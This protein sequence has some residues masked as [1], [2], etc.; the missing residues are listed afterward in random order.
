[1][2]IGTV[3][4]A[5]EQ[6]LGILVKSFF[7]AGILT[8][9]FVVEHGSRKNQNW[10]PNA[11][12]GRL[13]SRADKLKAQELCK[14]MDVMFFFETPFDWSLI[15]FCKEHGVKTILMPMYECMPRELPYEPD[16][17][18]NPSHLDQDYYPEG[19][20]IPI[21]VT[22]EWNQRLVANKFVHNAGHFGLKG[23]NG[24]LEL[25]QAVEHIKKPI[26][27][28]I[29]SQSGMDEM[30]NHVPSVAND[31]R[32]TIQQGSI[33]YEELWKEGDVFVF[34]EKF[35]GLSLPLQEAR[36]AG[37][38]VMAADRFPMNNWLPRQP[39]IPVEGYQ[40]S[41]I[42]GRCNEFDEAILNPI[43]IAE[44]ID[45]WHGGNIRTYSDSG[46]EWAKTMSWEA[47]KPQ[48]MEAIE[49]VLSM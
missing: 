35:N 26:E 14:K 6:G 44:T 7:D 32:V 37:M 49:C 11:P 12:K 48:Y 33:P 42:S 36:A 40:K 41:A 13:R 3:N 15:P 10:Y 20:H 45:A 43:K 21:P 1:M 24:T 39:L 22:M 29:R 31:P 25:L 38:L 23:R 28:V 16:L 30:L 17:I 2:R 18:I 4:Y 46:K 27:L 34:P 9:I 19:T 8:D 5:T 47:L